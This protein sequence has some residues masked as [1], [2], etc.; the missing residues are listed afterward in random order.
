MFHI[1]FTN[2]LVLNNGFDRSFIAEYTR[3]ESFA[4]L[5]EKLSSLALFQTVRAAAC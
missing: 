3:Y 4:M 5:L 2:L 1:K